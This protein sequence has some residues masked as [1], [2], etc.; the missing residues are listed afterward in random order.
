MCIGKW[1]EL[2]TDAAKI[3]KQIRLHIQRGA[4]GIT[5]VGLGYCPLFNRLGILYEDVTFFLYQ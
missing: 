4:E 1:N 2:M 5:S 3:L